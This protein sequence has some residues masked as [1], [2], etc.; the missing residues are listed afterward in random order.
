MKKAREI[1]GGRNKRVCSQFSS[2]YVLCRPPPFAVQLQEGPGLERGKQ[3]TAQ[4]KVGTCLRIEFSNQ[5]PFNPPLSSPLLL[6][7]KTRGSH[8]S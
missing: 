4:K 5:D 1:Q 8:P 7:L 6:M 3:E 2:K